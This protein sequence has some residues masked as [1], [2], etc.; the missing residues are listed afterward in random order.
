[1]KDEPSSLH[2][3]IG[4]RIDL[5]SDRIAAAAREGGI[6][7]FAPR[8][9]AALEQF[10]S[11]YITERIYEEARGL[12]ET[13]EPV[14]QEY[15]S[16]HKL[17]P[18]DQVW[19]NL[20]PPRVGT[21]GHD[22]LLMLYDV[23]CDFWMQLHAERQALRNLS[24]ENRRK[25]NV[26]LKWAPVFKKDYIDDDGKEEMRPFNASAKLFLAVAKLFDP[27][28]TARQCNAVVDRAKNRRRTAGGRERLKDRRRT[29]AKRFRRKA[30]RLDDT[31]T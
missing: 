18:P 1:M 12:R 19:G 6:A 10:S 4:E 24:A 17:E 29:A 22:T 7:Q 27:V 9:A 3:D 28:Y 15:V 11:T 23:L 13:Y 26:I 21:P 14:V 16:T 2:D 25:F 30:K 31:L 20:F 5:S 8:L